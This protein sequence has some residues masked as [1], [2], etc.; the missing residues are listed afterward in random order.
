[1]KIKQL[2]EKIFGDE[3]DVVVNIDKAGELGDINLNEPP[4]L[5]NYI[6]ASGEVWQG[7]EIVLHLNGKIVY[8]SKLLN[9]SFVSAD[10]PLCSEKK[11]DNRSI[12]DIL[13]QEQ[14]DEARIWIGEYDSMSEKGVI[15]NR[16]RIDIYKIGKEG[17]LWMS[18]N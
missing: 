18:A 5:T 15:K 13:L 16:I 9:R 12:I 2:L 10:M 8:D 17:M 3:C 14:W 11:E 7:S 6:N 1:M 4:F